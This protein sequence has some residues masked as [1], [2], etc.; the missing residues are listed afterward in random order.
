MVRKH[1]STG[2]CLVDAM[3]AVLGKLAP[4]GWDRLK[5]DNTFAASVQEFQ[6][7]ARETWRLDDVDLEPVLYT[8]T[9][10]DE[11]QEDDLS[12][13]DETYEG[14]ASPPSRL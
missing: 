8:L 9:H 2:E 7:E 5:E 6:R 3:R 11:E 1:I 10:V 12:E 14:P 4:D 13:G